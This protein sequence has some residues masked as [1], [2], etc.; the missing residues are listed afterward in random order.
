MPVTFTTALDKNITV[1]SYT[2]PISSFA[3]N[4]RTSLQL[5]DYTVDWDPEKA[6]WHTPWVQETKVL[7]REDR[8]VVRA[9][10][11]NGAKRPCAKISI[12]YDESGNGIVDEQSEPIKVGK[13]EQ[14]HEVSDIPI[15]EDG[16][17]RIKI[18][19]YSGYNSL[20]SLDMGII[21]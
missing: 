18:E 17:Y 1:E 8:F 10:V 9:S 15:S 21:N 16:Y 19:E 4:E 6:V 20:T 7:G 11:V 12:Q 14:L 5:L 2:S 13:E 3:T